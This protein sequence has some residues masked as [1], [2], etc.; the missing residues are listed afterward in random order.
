MSTRFFVD[1]AGVYLGGYDGAEPPEG[2]IEVEAAPADARQV[3]NGVGFDPP[4][5]PPPVISAT[6][7]LDRLGADGPVLMQSPAFA[8]QMARL[9]AAG[10]IRLDDSDVVA[11]MQAAVDGGA[12]SAERAAALLAAP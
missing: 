6:A 7:F 8:F 12:I 3:W 5:A 11:G 9:A 4:P 10:T 1:G 2:A